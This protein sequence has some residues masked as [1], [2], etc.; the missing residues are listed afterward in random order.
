LLVSLYFVEELNYD[1]IKYYYSC[2][3]IDG[4]DAKHIRI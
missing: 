4:K 2:K 1:H 3:K